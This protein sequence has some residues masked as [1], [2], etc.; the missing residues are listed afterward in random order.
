MTT[1]KHDENGKLMER[2]YEREPSYGKKEDAGNFGWSI[3]RLA[4]IE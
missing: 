4:G 3:E 1:D 2:K